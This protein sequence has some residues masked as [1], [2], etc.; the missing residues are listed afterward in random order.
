V[1][2]VVSRRAHQQDLRPRFVYRERPMG[3]ADSG[4][5]VLVGDESRGELDDPGAMLVL[6]AG[7]L[8]DR[9]PEL[10]SVFETE[11]LESQWHWDDGRGQYVRVT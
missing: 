6:N 9:W 8:T 1:Q 11:D 10:E 5:S 2:V 3:P 7:S 4:W